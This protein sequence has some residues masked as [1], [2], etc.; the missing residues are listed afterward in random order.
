ML[1]TNLSTRPFYNTRIV[2]VGLI[3]IAVVAAGLTV[4][5]AVE[6][7]RLQRAN[8]EFSDTVKQNDEAAG[9]LRAKAQ[10]VQQS[11]DRS[12]LAQVD[13]AAREANALIDRRA[14]SWTELLNQFQ[15]TLPPSVRITSVQ[16][17]VDDEG[18]MLVAITVLSRQQEDLDSFIAAL[19]K[20]GVFRDVLPRSDSSME[21]GSLMS[22]LQAFYHVNP[23]AAITPPPASEPGTEPPANRSAGNVVAGGRP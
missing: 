9:A 6:L 18:Q 17:Q 12:L 8:R 1:R 22:V 2:R 7:L 20:T 5:N 14:F 13:A 4:F 23:S 11:L 10:T 15:A 16:P 3:A 19:E 21:D